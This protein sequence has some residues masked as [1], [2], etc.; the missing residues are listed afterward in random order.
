MVLDLEK[1]NLFTNDPEVR[2]GRNFAD[3]E[4]I[5]VMQLRA[6]VEELSSLEGVL[7]DLDSLVAV[8]RAKRSDL[9]DVQARLRDQMRLCQEEIGLGGRWGSKTPAGKVPP[10]LDNSPSAE[11]TT[12]RDLQD[13]FHDSSQPVEILENVASE[14]TLDD[15]FSTNEDT[16]KSLDSMLDKIEVG[17]PNAPINIED[18]LQDFDL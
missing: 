15:L 16:E 7:D 10:S 13:M 3:R 18:L 17:S 12:L 9:R 8:I 6:Q 1:K 4:A 5:A 11:R 14:K 2:A